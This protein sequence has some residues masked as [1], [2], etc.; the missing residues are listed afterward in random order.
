MSL[1]MSSCE[2]RSHIAYD[3]IKWRK[4]AF[5]LLLEIVISSISLPKSNTFDFFHWEKI[6]CGYF[7]TLWAELSDNLRP[8]SGRW[9]KVEDG[10]AI[11]QNWIFF[12][13]LE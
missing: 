8:A 9:A 7:N 11:F 1:E 2:I 12:I 6:N 4:Y 3:C 13:Y 5:D 10:F